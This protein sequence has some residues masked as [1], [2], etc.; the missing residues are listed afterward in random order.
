MKKIVKPILI[1]LASVIALALIAIG[2]VVW[3]V[4]TPQKLTPIVR[5]QAVNYLTCKTDI[6]EV[7]L[8]FFSTFPSFGLKANHVCLINPV[9]GAPNDTLFSA[10]NV[11]GVVDLGAWWNNDQIVLTEVKATNGQLNLFTDS[12][13]H[14]NY[15]VMVTDTTEQ[16]TS[17]NTMAV[18][19]IRHVELNNLSV[20]YVDQSLKFATH[21]R[22]M[23]A[24][25]EGILS[26][27]KFNGHLNVAQSAV[28]LEYDSEKYLQS[29]AVKLDIPVEVAFSPLLIKLNN[30]HVSVNDLAMQFNGTVEID[31]T[32]NS[33]TTNLA[34][35]LD[36]WRLKEALSLTPPSYLNYLNGIDAD[37]SISSSGKL[38]G[39]YN[40]TH[41][42]VM[43]ILLSVKN[44]KLAYEGLPFPLDKINGRV[45]FY[46]DM[47][48][49]SISYV[50]IDQFSGRTTN[51]SFSVKGNIDQLFS[52]IR[53]RL[54]TNASLLLAEL[55]PLIP[56]EMKTKLEG[57][58]TGTVKA[59]FTL[60]QIDKMQLE[61]LNLSGQISVSDLTAVYDSITVRT[62]LSSLEF[63][64]PN[65]KPS[66]QKARFAL[67]KLNADNL[68]ASKTK[69]FD[70]KLKN[71]LIRIETSDMRDTTILPHIHATFE[72][73]ELTAGMDTLQLNAQSPKGIFGVAP[74][75]GHP[76]E[77][78]VDIKYQGGRLL[79]AMGKETV[80]IEKLSLDAN[81]ENHSQEKDVFLQW[82]TK[83]FINLDKGQ[84]CLSSFK[85]PFEIPS[86]KMDFTPENL[87]IKEGTVTIDK[88]DFSLTGNV[89]NVLSY[90]RGDSILK[91]DLTFSSQHIDIAQ[92]MNLTNGIGNEDTTSS[93][94]GGPYMVPKK[95]DLTLHTDIQKATL[96]ID[97][98]SKVHGDVRV[99]DGILVLD[100]I[101]CTSPATKMQ[102][103]AMYRSERKNHL[104]LGIDY[105]MFDVDIENL[106]K[107]IPD[108]DTIMPMLKS[109]KG[110]A[111][112]HT[113]T[114]TYMDSLYNLKKSTIRSSSSIKGNDLVLMDGQTF[115]EIAKSLNFR[116]KTVNKVDTLSAE[117]TIFKDEIDIYPFLIVMDKYKAIVAGRHNLDMTYKY[118]ISVVDCPLPIKLGVDITGN[119]DDFKYKV[120][121]CVL[122]KLYRP[123][124]QNLVQKQQLDLRKMM[125]DALK[126]KNK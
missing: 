17:E 102:L 11:L 112:F 21:I 15:D 101:K 56:T 80:S 69:S 47:A 76:L 107:M 120:T 58:A 88:S 1:I 18:I 27:N 106:L 51:S 6:G 9:S 103:T 79:A 34:Y 40:D 122:D 8:T 48:T 98:I 65:P 70:A 63:A 60:A 5:K 41:Y 85:Y 49:D 95:M 55:N 78:I 37:G 3:L 97:T 33:Y 23:D 84:V 96:G 29:S 52:D 126:R 46:S 42:P 99:M 62:N 87:H 116:K 64:L 74:R 67:A 89:S 93:S 31:S 123:I 10:S 83:G 32:F 72:M 45:A 81:V 92:L 57:R 12:L 14:T 113:V 13:G 114:E 100:D 110:K 124:S 104:F 16:T 19:D 25:L 7:E 43:D 61:K 22:N 82:L 86:I 125:Y 4:F 53:C 105:H 108:I 66:D 30:A 71:A 119:I 94:T 109:F 50:R 68:E 77:P 117:F 39:T 111:E 73:E 54:E 75:Q 121:P 26:D 59:D 24:Q 44:G 90:F 38:T 91:S 2:I 118:K 36:D 20:G 28:W 115:S 35:Q